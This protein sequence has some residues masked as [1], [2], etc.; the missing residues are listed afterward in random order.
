M[1]KKVSPS[2]GLGPYEIAKIRSAVRQVWHR[3]RARKICVSRCTGADRFLYCELCGQRTP[4]LKVDHITACGEVDEGFI[5]R[6]FC[7]STDLQG[8]CNDCHK[9]KTKQERL[10]K[11]KQLTP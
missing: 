4:T 5:K 1:T 10:D 2:D 6:M 7:P 11:K 3:S 9:A 8:M